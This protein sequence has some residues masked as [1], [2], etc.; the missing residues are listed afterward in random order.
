[1]SDAS[2]R[3]PERAVL[4]A[5]YIAAVLGAGAVP[6]LLPP[7]LDAR[8]RD[9]LLASADGLLL[10]GGA[11]VDPG[12][13]GE[14]PHPSVTGTSPMRDMAERALI[15]RA[16]ARELPILAIC[17]GM[18]MLNV[19]LGGSLIQDVPTQ[20]AGALEH[21]QTPDHARGEP[22]HTV[23]IE[24]G[25]RL[26]TIVGRDELVVNSMHHQALGR[27]GAGLAATAWAGDGVIEAA[28]LPGR[29]VLAVQW[30]PE[31]LVAEHKHARALFTWLA[32]EA[33]GRG[34]RR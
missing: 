31:E 9:E 11:D 21:S 2:G 25:S 28:E 32:R 33:R 6:V 5:A 26:A 34:R 15:E 20:V 8:A 12:T 22:T 23:A 7:Q 18:Q 27:M 24:A 30:H 10:T 1:M 19:A 14:T 3:G 29:R 16:M 4:N 13:Y 17:R